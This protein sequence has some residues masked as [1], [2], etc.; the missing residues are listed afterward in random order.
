MNPLQNLRK[1]DGNHFFILFCSKA[2][3][4]KIDISMKVLSSHALREK[5]PYLE[6]SWSVF[7]RNRNKYGEI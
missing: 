1:D 7:S 2:Q 6:F 3:N 4:S 5:C